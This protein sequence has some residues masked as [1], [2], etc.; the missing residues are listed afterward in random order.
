MEFG[1]DYKNKRRIVI[2]PEGEDAEPV[3]YLVPRGKHLTVQEGDVI[4]RGDVSARRQ[5]GSA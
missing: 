5:S 2:V 4:Q 1:R 3:E